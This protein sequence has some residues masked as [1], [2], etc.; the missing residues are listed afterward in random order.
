MLTEKERY[1]Y[2]QVEHFLL[3]I[4]K[5]TVKNP[6]EETRR[7]YEFLQT[8]ESGLLDGFEHKVVHVAGTNGKGSVCAF[9]ESIFRKSGKKTGMFTSPHLVTMR[10]RFRIDGVPVSEET[11]VQAFQWVRQ[12]VEQIKNYQPTFFEMLF[13]MSL[14]IFQKEAVDIILLET[15][16]GGRLDATNV[17]EHPLLTII[18]E[19]GLDHT[20]YL[21]DTIEKIAAEKA[22]ILKAGVPVVFGNLYAEKKAAAQVILERASQLQSSCHIVEKNVMKLEKIKEKSI[23]FSMHTRYYDYIRLTVKSPAVYQAENAA[24]AVYA[25]EAL[26][27]LQMQDTEADHS[28]PYISKDVLEQGIMD[29]R[30][31][32]RMEEVLPDVYIDGGHNQDGIRAFLQTVGARKQITG[33]AESKTILLFSVVKDKAYKEMIPMI[34]ESGYFDEIIITSIPGMRCVSAEELSTLF[35]HYTGGRLRTF[36]N[37]AEAFQMAMQDKGEKDHVYVAGSLYLAGI[38][39]GLLQEGRD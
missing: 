37:P 35:Q 31:E 23:D 33:A 6:M 20:Q 12:Y 4:P 36:E 10:E 22:G 34:V 1:S 17:T 2:K 14:F 9:L 18:T 32:A 15:G 28:K 13:F 27:D 5:F 38:L 16:L 3:E 21:G 11:F 19:I 7:F 30:W 39:K 29:M 25:C 24:L 26:N 8:K